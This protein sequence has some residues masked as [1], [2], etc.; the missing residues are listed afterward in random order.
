MSSKGAL[1]HTVIGGGLNNHSAVIFLHI[2]LIFVGRM[3]KSI[4]SF[5]MY[6]FSLQ[7]IMKTSNILNHVTHKS[8]TQMSQHIADIMINVLLKRIIYLGRFL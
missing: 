8:G 7:V 2:S 1:S 4:P 6:P 3:S 5:L